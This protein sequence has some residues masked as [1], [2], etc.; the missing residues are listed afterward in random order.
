MEI[1]LDSA[2]SLI[3]IYFFAMLEFLSKSELEYFV[4]EF[5]HV[6]FAV[7]VLHNSGINGVCKPVVL[8]VSGINKP[9]ARDKLSHLFT[10]KCI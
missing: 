10:G 2:P 3:E 8:L 5:A 9:R 4:F 1:T 7:I 6:I